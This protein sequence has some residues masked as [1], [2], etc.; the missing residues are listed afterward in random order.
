[1]SVL[2]GFVVATTPAASPAFIPVQE[3]VPMQHDRFIADT[4]ANMGYIVHDDGSYTAFRIGSGQQKT[5]HYMGITYDAAT[6]LAH[7]EVKSTTIQ[8][9]R[10]TF[11][12]TGFFLRLYENGKDYTSYGIHSTG[13]INDI[14][15]GNDRYK[16]MGCILVSNQVLN[17]LAKTYE[18]NDHDLDVVTVFGLSDLLASATNM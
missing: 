17:L 1:M 6:P 3:W 9:D 5:V 18:L 11:G 12:P 16:S 15:A 4:E 8:T 7:W 2:F 10:G 14:L 13:N